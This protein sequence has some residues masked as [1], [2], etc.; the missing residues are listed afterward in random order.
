MNK[1]LTLKDLS[2]DELITAVEATPLLSSFF[3]E[4]RIAR[5]MIARKYKEAKGLESALEK[6][7]E[8]IKKC[9]A[10]KT[11]FDLIKRHNSRVTR[12]AKLAGE[13]KELIAR[14]PNIVKAEAS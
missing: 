1:K 2:K 7:L 4:E 12:H 13:C 3:T 8:T 14:F 11:K 6:S 10:R 9:R 5:L